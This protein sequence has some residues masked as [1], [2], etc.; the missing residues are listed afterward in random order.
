MIN[1]IKDNASNALQWA[2]GGSK[3]TYAAIAIGLIIALI[4]FRMFF[5]NVAGLFHSI[6]FSF[7]AG[8]DPTV[9]ADPDLCS[10]SRVKLL[11][12]ATVPV[13]AGYA[14]Y[15]LLPTLFPT[16]FQ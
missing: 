16:I 1:S 11:H 3:I 5:K 13:C 8:G 7:G 15:A 9:A 6:G 14:A 12:I 10:S 4:L 2:A